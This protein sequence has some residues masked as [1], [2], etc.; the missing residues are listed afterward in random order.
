MQNVLV[1]HITGH[2]GLDANVMWVE[3]VGDGPVGI[4]DHIFS[5]LDQPANESRVGMVGVS[6]CDQHA[7]DITDAFQIDLTALERV[8]PRIKK[9]A[10]G[11]CGDQKT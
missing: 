8:K 6:M 11:V 9:G 4:D 5:S 7:G 10:V 2:S 1:S 3:K